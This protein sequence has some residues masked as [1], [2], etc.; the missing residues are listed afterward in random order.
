MNWLEAEEGCQGLNPAAHLASVSSQEENDFIFSLIKDDSVSYV[1]LGGSD[2]YSEGDWTWSDG[3]LFDFTYWQNDGS[4]GNGGPSQ[5]CLVM[6]TN[7][8]Y[9]A[10]TWYDV[11]CYHKYLF[12]C[13][14]NM[15]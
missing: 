1:W 9:Y 7:N 5:N 3:S 11:E 10:K 2:S 15:S 4:Q 8:Q 14:I 12:I 6:N 13:E